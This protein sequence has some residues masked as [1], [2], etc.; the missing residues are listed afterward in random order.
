[1]RLLRSGLSRQDIQGKTKEIVDALFRNIPSG[2]GS[3]R[4]DFKLSPKDQEKVLQQGAQW[5][6]RQGYGSAKDLE[7]IEEGGSIEG[8][9]PDLVSNRALERG[10]DQLGTLGSGNHFV[11]VGYVETIYDPAAAR[12]LGLFE[13]QVTVMVHTGSRGLGHQVCDDSIKQLIRATAKYGIDLPD[14]QLCCAPI[15]SPEGRDYLGA[16]A[17]AA[18]FAF[19]NRQI[20]THWVQE[21]LERVLKRGPNDLRLELIYDLCHNIAK[22]EDHLVE[23]KMRKLCVHRKGATRAFPPRHP[24]IPPDFYELG[25]P[26]IIPG[27]MGRYSYVLLGTEQ[28]YAETFGST[29]HGAGR[30]MS[31]QAA[32]KAARGHAVLRELEDRGI[33]VR[34][35]G[36][37]TVVEEISEAYK[38]V[39]QVVEVVHGAGISRKV[40]RL[41]PM[42]VVKG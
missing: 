10:K 8:A 1:V 26:V 4:K 7:H 30:V 25:Q 28:A 12:A 15:N 38:D 14:R 35:A 29:C 6:V 13:E 5:A 31:R 17:A 20:I 21:T 40:A 36:M 23:G 9:R 18:N 42:G 2:V 11:E 32:K 33:I 27:D 16:M 37:G 19:A 34:G 24:Q 3:H 41:R 39:A 22:F